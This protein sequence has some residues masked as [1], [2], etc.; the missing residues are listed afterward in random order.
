MK[1]WLST[2]SKESLKTFVS[3]TNQPLQE[4]CSKVSFFKFQI[5][6]LFFKITSLASSLLMT[7]PL[8][9]DQSVLC[10]I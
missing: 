10:Y 5:E 4:R 6:H 8:E 9:A 3:G 2:L 1:S 7:L